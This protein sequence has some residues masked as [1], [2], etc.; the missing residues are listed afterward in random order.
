MIH[1][2][3]RV[4]SPSTMPKR[5]TPE[6]IAAS[7]AVGELRTQHSFGG[8]TEARHT[9]QESRTRSTARFTPTRRCGTHRYAAIALRAHARRL[10]R[11]SADVVRCAP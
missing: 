1:D 6:Q 4:V 9:Y 11:P 5:F 2:P 8:D 7:A 10:T 3:R